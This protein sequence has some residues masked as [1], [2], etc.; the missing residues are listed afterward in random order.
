MAASTS[1]CLV[2][3]QLGLAAFVVAFQD[4]ILDDVFKERIDL[5]GG[6]QLVGEILWGLPMSRVVDESNAEAHPDQHL[7]GVG[8][9]LVLPKLDGWLA[10]RDQVLEVELVISALWVHLL[11][12]LL[13]GRAS[14]NGTKAPAIELGNRAG[15][16]RDDGLAALAVVVIDTTLGHEQ[17]N[18]VLVD[19]IVL[20][21][22][23]QL[24]QSEFLDADMNVE[25]HAAV[26]SKTNLFRALQRTNH[27]VAFFYV[28]LSS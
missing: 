16:V 11:A 21:D 14:S 12:E 23:L 10:S 26:D 3:R 28:V 17:I 4:G 20:A 22:L 5:L 25:S 8:G 7:V 9:G 13:L 19:N 15:L 2:L 6:A 24:I 27:A 18:G 1:A